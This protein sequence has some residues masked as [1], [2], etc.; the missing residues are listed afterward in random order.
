MKPAANGDMRPHPGISFHKM[1]VAGVG[2]ALLSVAVVLIALI[3]LPIAK[4]FLLGS[5]GLGWVVVGFLML[6][7]KLKPKTEIEEV[8][9]V[10]GQRPR[11]NDQRP[12]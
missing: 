1:P 4:W 7:R 10:V 8:Q 12:T 6:T 9:L 5:L 11:T 3:G 2:G